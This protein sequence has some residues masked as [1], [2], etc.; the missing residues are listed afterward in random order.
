MALYTKGIGRVGDPVAYSVRQNCDALTAVTY[1]DSQSKSKVHL[2]IL[3]IWDKTFN[4]PLVVIKG[5]VPQELVTDEVIGRSGGVNDKLSFSTLGSNPNKARVSK[6]HRAF[7]QAM[8]NAS[9]KRK[10]K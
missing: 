1:S 9:D 3:P 2:S 10:P 6:E 4:F 5:S 8:T 7:V